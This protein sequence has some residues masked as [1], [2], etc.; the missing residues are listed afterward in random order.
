MFNFC[1]A[2]QAYRDLLIIRLIFH[3]P[4][5]GAIQKTFET[6]CSEPRILLIAYGQHQ[7]QTMEVKYTDVDYTVFSD[8]ARYKLI[9]LRYSWVTDIYISGVNPKW[10]I[11]DPDPAP[12]FKC[13][14]FRQKFRI[15]PQI[16]LN[17]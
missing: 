2:L 3:D 16:I 6:P 4:L 15:P 17:V 7:D 12:T 5:L 1:Y 9:T 13:S 11:P 8:A 14:R 10:L